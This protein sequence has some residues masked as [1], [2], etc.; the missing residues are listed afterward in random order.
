MNINSPITPDSKISR[1][2]TKRRVITMIET[3]ADTNTVFLRQRNQFVNLL[4]GN[5]R[6]LFH[7]HV[8]ARANRRGGNFSQ[9][10]IDGR[11][12][13]RVHLRIGDGLFEIGNGTTGIAPASRVPRRGPGLCRRPQRVLNRRA[14]RPAVFSQS[15]R[16]R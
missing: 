7:E 3:H 9:R 2:L 8:F 13:H 14:T 1:A 4:N 10:G 16:N 12:D 5:A 11:H 6:W 15:I